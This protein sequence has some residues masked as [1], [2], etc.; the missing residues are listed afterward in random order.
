MKSFKKLCIAFFIFCGLIVVWWTIPLKVHP[1]EEFKIIIDPI[2]EEGFSFVDYGRTQGRNYQKFFIVEITPEIFSSILGF[3]QYFQINSKERNEE[4]DRKGVPNDLRS[5]QFDGTYRSFQKSFPGRLPEN[6]NF[7]STHEIY[8][9]RRWEYY[10]GDNKHV[11]YLI[12][13]KE[14]TKLIVL[15]WFMF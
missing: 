4:Y 5:R 13:N 3:R 15:Y 1:Y 7:Y 10:S 12:V 6:K 2:P 11:R 9:P 8:T 14:H